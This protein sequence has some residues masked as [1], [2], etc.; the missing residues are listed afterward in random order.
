MQV[1]AL[2]EQALQ[3]GVLSNRVERQILQQVLFTRMDE[4]EKSAIDQLTEALYRGLI[5]R[6]TEAC[7]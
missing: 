7:L 3:T 1:T 2:V 6:T 4:Q 5:Q